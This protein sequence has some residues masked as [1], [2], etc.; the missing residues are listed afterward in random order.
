MQELFSLK[1]GDIMLEQEA[2][3]IQK[4]A[5]WLHTRY[6]D[7][8]NILPA[9]PTGKGQP[10]RAGCVWHIRSHR[11]S[12]VWE[13]VQQNWGGAAAA[14]AAASVLYSTHSQGCPVHS[15]WKEGLEFRVRR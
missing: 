10:L 2:R 13:Q 15:N 8:N 3:E 7:E 6:A 14:A 12:F 9:P 4:R 5:L 1:K 11:G